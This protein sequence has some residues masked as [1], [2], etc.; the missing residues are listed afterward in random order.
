MHWCR[1]LDGVSYAKEVL[2]TK[3]PAQRMYSKTTHV[4]H[5]A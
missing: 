5:I 3:L 2:V 4:K 1:E